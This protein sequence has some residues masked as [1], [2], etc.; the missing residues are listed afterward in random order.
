VRDDDGFTIL[1][2]VVAIALF[3]IVA[4]AATFAIVSSVRASSATELR[5]E[6]T[7]VA[8]Q[9]LDQL[10][11]LGADPEA[12]PALG[13]DADATYTVAVTWGAPCSSTVRS[14]DVAV[15][16][17]VAGSS[18]APVTLDTRIACGI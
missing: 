17:S 8:Q 18:I 15:R 5:I 16:V 9:H 13:G 1:E 7:H 12:S 14:R 2:V 4:S 10:R 6:A 3:A 11:A